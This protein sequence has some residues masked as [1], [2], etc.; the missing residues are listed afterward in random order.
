[1]QNRKNCCIFVLSKQ[2]LVMT[3]KKMAGRPKAYQQKVMITHAIEEQLLTRL[4]L[5]ADF[6]NTRTSLI[7]EAIEEYLKKRKA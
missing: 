7:N 3:E 4:N 2:H 1:M 5:F 6:N